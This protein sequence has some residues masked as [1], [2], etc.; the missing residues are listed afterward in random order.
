MC[1]EHRRA[2]VKGLREARQ[3]AKVSEEG[4]TVGGGEEADAA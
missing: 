3:V 1:T 4:T 2:Y